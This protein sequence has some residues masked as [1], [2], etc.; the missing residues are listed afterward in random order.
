[1]IQNHKILPIQKTQYPKYVIA[2]LYPNFPKVISA[3][4]FLK[5]LSRYNIELFYDIKHK[6]DFFQIAY[7]SEYRNILQQ[8]FS[9]F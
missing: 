5:K 4:K 3:L 9:L 2:Q 1:M 6:C 7:S 8:G